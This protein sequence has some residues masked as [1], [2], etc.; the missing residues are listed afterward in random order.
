MCYAR[1]SVF[2]FSFMTASVHLPRIGHA[3]RGFNWYGTE[4]LIRKH[5]AARGI[6]T[7]MY[8]SPVALTG[9]ATSPEA[10]SSTLSL[11]VER[12][13][14]KRFPPRGDKHV[15][16]LPAPTARSKDTRGGLGWAICHYRRGPQGRGLIR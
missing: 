10:S 16:A 2:F 11:F 13:A 7:Y 1:P 9:A 15:P 4:R 8:P 14:E 5:L 12:R 6:P 3:T